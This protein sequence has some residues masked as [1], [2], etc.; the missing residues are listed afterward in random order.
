MARQ[1]RIHSKSLAQ[2]GARCVKALAKDGKLF[3]GMMK[4][5]EVVYE[6]HWRSHRDMRQL[7]KRA[8]DARDLA[9]AY[10]AEAHAELKE[11]KKDGYVLQ[12]VA[13]LAGKDGLRPE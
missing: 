5:D 2:S 4:G 7:V 9:K 13:K 1:S 6:K 3:F 12:L 11:S 10:A 8:V